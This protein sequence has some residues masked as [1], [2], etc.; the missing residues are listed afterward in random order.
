MNILIIGA[1][2]FVAN[3]LIRR[4]S[5]QKEMRVLA[6]SRN[7]ETVFNEFKN[8]ENLSVQKFNFVHDNPAELNFSPEVV[9]NLSSVQ[10][11][12]NKVQWQDFLEGNID[13]VSSIVNYAKNEDIKKII[14]FSTSSVYAPSQSPI[15]D[16]TVPQPNT[17]YG[18]SK[19]TGENL[20]RISKLR[21]EFTSD[22]CVLRFPSI[23][24]DLHQAGIIHTYFSLASRNKDIELFY[25]GKS[26][27]NI[28]FVEDVIDIVLTLLNSNSIQDFEIY[29]LGSKNELTT[30]EISK[31]IIE[32]LDSLS[33]LIPLK[34]PEISKQD[35]I[36]DVERFSR[37]YN[38]EPNLIEE[39]LTRYIKSKDRN[40]I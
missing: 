7:I 21:N 28:I 34:S 36:I 16:Q 6:V 27:R 31:F 39:S 11:S 19:L 23:Y 15:N 30:Y 26:I 3:S 38:Y 20:L 9:I 17:Y 13:T 8:L 37:N 29:N 14:H 33:N 22:A 25:E 12:S 5:K 24:G 2:G 4:L 10:P 40:P 1:S 32:E 35:V 18:L